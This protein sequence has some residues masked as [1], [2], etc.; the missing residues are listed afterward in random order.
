[1][2]G[3]SIQ[4]VL[5]GVSPSRLESSRPAAWIAGLAACGMSRT[6]ADPG[7]GSLEPNRLTVLDGDGSLT[8]E[9][10]SEVRARER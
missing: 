5:R 4:Y 3:S 9:V 1:M 6:S 7:G 10:A 2:A 8:L